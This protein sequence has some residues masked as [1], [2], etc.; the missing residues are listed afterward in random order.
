MRMVAPGYGNINP[1]HLFPKPKINPKPCRSY[2]LRNGLSKLLLKFGWKTNKNLYASVNFLQW[3]H[4][5]I[6]NYE[7]QAN[8]SHNI[9]L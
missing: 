9:Q 6:Y 2:L 3:K 5:I 8:S 1:F 4:N 7:I